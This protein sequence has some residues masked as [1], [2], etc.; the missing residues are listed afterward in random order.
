MPR[1]EAMT[2]PWISVAG[3]S[4]P[5]AEYFCRSTVPTDEFSMMLE[6]TTVLG[7][8]MRSPAAVRSVVKPDADLFDATFRCA[9]TN[10]V[11]DPKGPLDE[12]VDPVDESA[13]DILKGE[14]DAE[15][16]SAENGRDSGPTGANNRQDHGSADGVDGES[17][18]PAHQGRDLGVDPPRHCGS[19]H[20]AAYPVRDPNREQDDDEDLNCSGHC[21]RRPGARPVPAPT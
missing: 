10:V 19:P 13:A 16:G 17:R 1:S 11:S 5:V 12:N 18:R 4:I 2:A 7:T 21:L 20:P 9:D 6:N 14:T 8:M 3:R 15:G